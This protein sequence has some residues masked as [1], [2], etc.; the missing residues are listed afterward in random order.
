MR[1]DKNKD[2]IIL[3]EDDQSNAKW[4]NRINGNI[5]LNDIGNDIISEIRSHNSYQINPKV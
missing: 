5:L 3:E 2:W 4:S 1:L